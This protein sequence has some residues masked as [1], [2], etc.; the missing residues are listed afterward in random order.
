M[1]N[2]LLSLWGNRIGRIG[3]AAETQ[4]A[5]TT[6]STFDFQSKGDECIGVD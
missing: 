2:Y 3:S 4:Q 1:V 5:M 6:Y